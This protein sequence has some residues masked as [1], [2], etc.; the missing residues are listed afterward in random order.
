MSIYQIILALVAFLFIWNGIAK[1]IRHERSQTIFK[2]GVST[3]IWGSVLAFALFPRVSFTV[4]K[5]IGLG[6]NLNTL[7][8]IGFVVVFIILFKLLSVIER[9]ERNL[10]EMVRKEALE[11]LPP[12]KKASL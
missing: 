10:S 3:L 7:I 8:F 6:E 2:L 1:F 4:S 5:A 12:K 11:K 9:L